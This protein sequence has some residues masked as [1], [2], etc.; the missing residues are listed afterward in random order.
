[1]VIDPGPLKGHI[2]QIGKVL[3]R[4][5]DRDRRI[6]AVQTPYFWRYPTRPTTA[7]AAHIESFRVRSQVGPRENSEIALERLLRLCY[8]HSRLVK[9]QPFFAKTRYSL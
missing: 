9:S 6:D 1:M 5:I 3:S 8:R 7:S 4:H 2:A